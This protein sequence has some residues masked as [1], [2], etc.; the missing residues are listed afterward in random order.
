MASLE[1]A[2]KVFTGN[3]LALFASFAPVAAAVAENDTSAPSGWWVSLR[4]SLRGSGQD[5][6][7]GS[8]NCAVGLLAVP[9]V[10]EM[11]GERLGSEV[12]AAVGLATVQRRSP[13][14]VEFEIGRAH[15]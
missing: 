12:L 3:A 9:M 5:F 11:L 10:R 14:V 6:T 1:T 2:A 4:E 13:H 15:V 7:R 8:L